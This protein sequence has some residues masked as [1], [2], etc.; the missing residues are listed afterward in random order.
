MRKQ[1]FQI[2]FLLLFP[3]IIWAQQDFENI[4]KEANLNVYRHPQKAIEVGERVYR[5]SKDVDI[6]MTALVILINAYNREHE[7]SLALDYANKALELASHSKSVQHQITALGLLGEQYQ[8]SHL[9]TISRDYLDQADSLLQHNKLAPDVSTIARG[10]LFAIRGNGYKDEIDCEFA[11]KNYDLAIAAYNAVPDLPVATNNLALVYIEKGSCL[12]DLGALDEAQRLFLRA[13]DLATAN[14][15]EEYV[16]RANLA[17]AEI[18][19]DKGN[20]TEAQN[21][22]LN[23]IKKMDLQE[24]LSESIKL[25]KLLALTYLHEGN[26]TKFLLYAQQ[27]QK[28]HQKLQ[29]REAV[30]F[31]QLYQYLDRHLV[32]KSRSFSLVDA[33]LYFLVLALFTI[34]AFEIWNIIKIKSTS[35]EKSG[36]LKS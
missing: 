33:L 23:L 27:I 5:E 15:L 18:D 22:A 12:K 8:L 24:D 21:A 2:V 17:L 36:S 1:I 10:N 31:Q 20:F 13:K 16:Q 3:V 6:K 7:S 19:L 26:Q 32:I 14:Q 29:A 28:A 34:V 25:Y 11:V 9:N 35:N 30:S 4:L